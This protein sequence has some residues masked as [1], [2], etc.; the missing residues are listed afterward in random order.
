MQ[1]IMYCI[2]TVKY[3]KYRQE[4]DFIKYIISKL[5]DENIQQHKLQLKRP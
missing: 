2:N 5:E 3:C 4:E 1:Y